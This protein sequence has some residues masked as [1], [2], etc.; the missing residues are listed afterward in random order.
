MLVISCL[1]WYFYVIAPPV[2]VESPAKIF[3]QA[4]VA[5]IVGISV[6]YRL[7]FQALRGGPA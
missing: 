7:A 5:M 3:Q 1:Y 2:W 4:Q 6:T